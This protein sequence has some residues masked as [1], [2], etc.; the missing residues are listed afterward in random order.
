MRHNHCQTL[1]LACTCTTTTRVSLSQQGRCGVQAGRGRHA[2]RDLGGAAGGRAATRRLPVSAAHRP[3]MRLMFH[4]LALAFHT[5]CEYPAYLD[6][7]EQP[8]L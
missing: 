1:T 5:P 6:D 4:A 7:F 2:R 3:G 8:L